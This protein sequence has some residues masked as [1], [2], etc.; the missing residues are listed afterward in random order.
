MNEIQSYRQAILDESVAI[1]SK[2]A[3]YLKPA[4]DNVPH[5]TDIDEA[6]IATWLENTEKEALRCAR[7]QQ[8]MFGLP[9]DESTQVQNIGAFK[10]Y[11][12]PII[13][14]AYSNSIA[15]KI[16]SEQALK[17]KQGQ[18]FFLDVVFGTDKGNVEQGDIMYAPQSAAP[19]GRTKYATEYVENEAHPSQGATAGTYLAEF[20]NVRPGTFKILVE[21][22]TTNSLD[23]VAHDDGAGKLVYTAD[24]T[25]AGTI[26]YST[27]TI[28]YTAKDTTELEFFYEYNSEM[29]GRGASL[30][31]QVDLQIREVFIKAR[32]MKLRSNYTF[33]AAYDLEVSQ[34]INI[35]A[36]LLE[37]AQA[38]LHFELDGLVMDD[39]FNGAALTAETWS[40]SLPEGTTTVYAL[41]RR[42]H[43]MD[44]LSIVNDA[45]NQIFTATG[46]AVGNFMLVG[47]KVKTVLETIGDPIFKATGQDGVGPYECGKLNGTITVYADP[48]LDQYAWLVG[49]KGNLWLDTGYVLGVYLPFYSTSVIM[50]D[51]FVG[52]RGYAMSVGR[53]MVNPRYYCK[54]V[55]TE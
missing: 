9:V 45:K 39:L 32:S 24:G 42:D 33:D 20:K 23:E 43:Y 27:G 50:M 49:Y 8:G 55:I 4:R 7:K 46:R 2:Y 48:Y 44:F 41:N 3:E 19:K 54:G 29:A 22:T 26:T 35:D 37:A 31:G 6:Y 38:E 34:N 53:R 12:F 1:R 21:N 52:R 28:T 14:A 16:V 11:A 30:A 25:A 5:L 13:T 18:L 36:T 47:A 10:R 17:Q 15:P 51:D 40:M